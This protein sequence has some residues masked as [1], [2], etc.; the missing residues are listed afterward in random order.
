MAT[1]IAI[2]GI[3]LVCVIS[4]GLYLFVKLHPTGGDVPLL[5]TPAWEFKELNTYEARLLL[6]RETTAGG[7]LLLKRTDS[8]T[9]YRYDPATRALT[10]VTDAEWQQATGEIRNCQDYMPNAPYSRPPVTPLAIVTIDN[11]DH[12]LLVNNREVPT[13]GGYSISTQVSPSEK[14]VAVLSA[15]GP[16]IPPL[17]PLGGDWTL[18]QRYHEI[19]SLPN[20][21][22]AGKAIK[23]PVND[24]KDFT[25]MCWSADE[26]LVVHTT[27]FFDLLV[28][29][30]TGV[31]SR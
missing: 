26:E 4:L 3:I 23:F 1:L 20:A 14:W 8:A 21:T 18:G 17:L 25:T 22:R 11:R 7:A 30:E 10:S 19:L 31:N 12:R 9:V 6:R 29:V 24:T 5:K 15:S 2:F 27:Y 13:A 16:V 28:V